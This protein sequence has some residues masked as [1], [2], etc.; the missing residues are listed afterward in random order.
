MSTHSTENFRIIVS[1]RE[2]L[3][4]EQCSNAIYW[5]IINYISKCERD[6]SKCGL[7]ELYQYIRKDDS[8]AE[9]QGNLEEQISKLD[10]ILNS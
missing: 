4:C 8:L 7:D 10:Q 6:F 1:K 9:R 2:G 5:T 3:I